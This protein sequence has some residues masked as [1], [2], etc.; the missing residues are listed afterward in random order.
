MTELRVLHNYGEEIEAL[1]HLKTFPFAVKLLKSEGDIPEGALRPKRD[2]GYH[3]ATCQ[4]FTRSRHCGETF[5]LLK[6]DMWCFESVLG[7]GMA[8]IPDYFLEGHNCYP[9]ASRTLESGAIWAREEFPHLDYGAC[10][11]VASAPLKETTFE[12]D[13]VVIYCDS[14]QL[15]R[16]VLAM[17]GGDGRDIR[18]KLSGRAA[19]VYEVVP[20][21]LEDKCHLTVPCPGDRYAAL[22]QDDELAFSVPKD[23]VEDLVLGLR[24]LAAQEPPYYRKLEIHPEY[25]L[26]ESYVKLGKM[27]G[28]DVW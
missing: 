10:I 26:A 23:K 2:L 5:A 22:A 9:G 8:E 1:L 3:L 19:C 11:G 14:A 24:H 18:C 15:T 13:A 28:M 7:F 16:M 27:V 6:E 4:A 12:P 25:K 20:S 17:V 21:V